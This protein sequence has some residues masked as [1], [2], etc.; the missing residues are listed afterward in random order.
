MDLTQVER[1]IIINALE[2]RLVELDDLIYDPE[3]EWDDEWVEEQDI[4]YRL[5]GKLE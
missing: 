1:D 2:T 4:I 5:I 3:L